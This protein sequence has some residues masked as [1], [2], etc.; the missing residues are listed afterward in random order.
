MRYEAVYELSGSTNVGIVYR[1]DS[2]YDPE[3][4]VGGGQPLG[5]DQYATLYYLYATTGSSITARFLGASGQQIKLAVWP[6]VESGTHSY[7]TGSVVPGAKQKLASG[8]DVK[9]TVIR[10]YC[11]S[12]KINGHK[13]S[14]HDRLT[15]VTGNPTIQPW[16]WHIVSE[17]LDSATNVNG[18]VQIVV[19]YY[20]TFFDR[21]VIADSGV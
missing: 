18:H 13:A 17:A 4:A 10:N 8:G 20:V 3:F 5:F 1:G 11:T 19:T 12:S 14:M 15:N 21:R 2:P 7:T 16:Y 9:S 6:S